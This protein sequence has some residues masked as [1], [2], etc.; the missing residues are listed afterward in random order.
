[1]FLMFSGQSASRTAEAVDSVMIYITAISLLLLLGVTITMIYFV[2]KY[3]RKKGHK[4]VDIHGNIWLEIVWIGI[5]TILVLT[6]FYY[7][8]MG[9]LTIREIPEDAFQ[10]NVTARMWEWQFDYENGKSTDTLFVPVKQPIVLKME[11]VDVNHSLY[12]PAF[13]IKE[14]VI[15][16]RINYLSFTADQTGSFD[17]ACA[18]YCGLKHSMMYTR[19]NVLPEDEFTAWYET[20]ESKPDTNLAAVS[21]ESQSLLFDKGCTTCHSLDGSKGVA[22]SFAGLMGKERVIIR[23]GKEMNI[24]VD[25]NY[26]RRSI[27]EP[28]A[29]TVKG[30]TA[31]LMPIQKYNLNDEEVDRLVNIIAGLN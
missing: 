27:L 19:I 30:Y 28:N 23:N 6:M 21:A 12:I 3:H 22:P 2:F 15:A 4:P 9:F 26:L 17:I 5:P 14:D 1:M 8:Y 10:I 7:G 13:R 16:G 18:E 24:T 25:E 29:E 20:E 11:S 31:G